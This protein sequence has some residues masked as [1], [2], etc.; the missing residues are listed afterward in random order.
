MPARAAT[1]AAQLHDAEQ[2]EPVAQSQSGPHAHS[3]PQA[4]DGVTGI[5]SGALA[6]QPQATV[7]LSDVMMPPVDQE[8]A[9]QCRS[10]C[11]GTPGCM[12]PT[13][14]RRMGSVP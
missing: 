11:M 5:G 7:V 14:R 1:H 6:A 10:A 12:P 4:Q 13:P 3:S 9:V 8:K 2:A